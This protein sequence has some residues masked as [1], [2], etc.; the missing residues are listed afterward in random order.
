MLVLTGSGQRLIAKLAR[1]NAVLRRAHKHLR[2]LALHLTETFIPKA[3][4]KAITLTRRFTITPGHQKG[5]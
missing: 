1:H 2:T 5:H 4:S 3:G